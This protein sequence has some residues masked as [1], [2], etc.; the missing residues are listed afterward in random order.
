MIIFKY[1]RRKL[2]GDNLFGLPYVISTDIDND[3]VKM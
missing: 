1:L 3:L 2:F